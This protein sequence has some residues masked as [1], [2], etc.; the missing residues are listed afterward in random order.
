M[1]SASRHISSSYSCPNCCPDTGPYGSFNPNAVSLLIDGFAQ[2]GILGAMS[3]CNYNFWQIGDIMGGAA[4]SVQDSGVL[5]WAS[6]QS[7]LIG[8]AVGTS[9]YYATWQFTEW[10]SDGMDCYR[11][12]YGAGDTGQAGIDRLRVRST[13][14]IVSS[15]NTSTSTVIVANEALPIF[16]EAVDANGFVD[17]ANNSTV[18]FSVP[19][20]TLDSSETGFPASFG[21]SSGSFSRNIVLN[22]VVGAG[23]GTTFRFSPS[24]GGNLDYFFFTY[25]RVIASREG[26]VGNTTACNYV[27]QANDHFVALPAANLCNAGITLLNGATVVNTT[28]RDKGPWFPNSTATTGNPCVGSDDPYWNTGGVPRVLSTNCDTNNAAIDLADGTFADLG[29]SGNTSILWRFR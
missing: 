26:L 3:D 23:A 24:A 17:T 10:D 21:L 29:L 16:V 19:N 5:T 2:V 27:I 7:S 14:T 13:A 28:V 25:F 9:D 1:V 11:M 22:R 4:L 12:Y 15:D 6:E 18:R 8:L 20:R